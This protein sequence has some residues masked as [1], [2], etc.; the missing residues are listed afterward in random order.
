[1]A[2]FGDDAMVIAGSSPY[3]KRG[4]LYNAWKHYFGKDNTENLIWVAPTREMNPTISQAFIDSE[5]ERDPASA[6]SEYLA[7]W[8]SD[9]QQFVDM[10]ILLACTADGVFEIP[11]VSG[12][13]YVAFVDPS[14]G[15]S[16]SMTLAITHREDD[17][18]AILDC[19]R[20]IV[21]PSPVVEDFCNT[22][23]Q[24]NID[25]VCG[26]RYAGL[27]PTFREGEVRSLPRCAAIIEQ[28]QVSVT[29]QSP[30]DS[31]AA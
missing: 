6:A 30:I 2:T 13:S 31:A 16:D 28:P 21:A 22:L 5:F 25:K 9:V 18:V 29:R 7:E 12:A 8:R 10:D 27:W 26:D 1:M 14:G 11:P 4:L 17:G 24:Y 23:K 19:I 3:A 20:E 15:S